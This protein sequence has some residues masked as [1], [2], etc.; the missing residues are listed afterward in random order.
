[1]QSN[2]ALYLYLSLSL[3]NFFFSSSFQFSSCESDFF[4]FFFGVYLLVARTSNQEA[5]HSHL[6][7]LEVVFHDIGVGL[8]GHTCH[9]VRIYI[10]RILFN[11][12][13]L[14]SFSSSSSASS[15]VQAAWITQVRQIIRRRQYRRMKGAS[16]S[17]RKRWKEKPHS[18]YVFAD[19]NQLWCAWL[20]GQYNISISFFFIEI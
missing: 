12:S 13:T 17:P 18:A 20:H 14:L 8:C 10:V 6:K 11:L 16:P 15:A 3:S 7:S 4:L 19:D 9:I 2:Y 1:M 5:A